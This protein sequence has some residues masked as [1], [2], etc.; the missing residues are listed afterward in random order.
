MM[1]V[2]PRGTSIVA[3]GRD[4]FQ[5]LDYTGSNDGIPFQLVH[6]A[7]VG[8]WSAASVVAATIITK[9]LVTDTL[10]WA[11]TDHTGAYAGVVMMD[12]YTARKISHHAV[13]RDMRQCS[14]PTTIVGMS[15]VEDGHGYM[16][17]TIPGVTT[18]VY[19]T[20]TSLWHERE[21]YEQ[22]HWNI[23]ATCT[24]G[25][26]IVGGHR[27][28]PKLYWVDPETYT[29]AGQPLVM[30]L[31]TPP[32]HGY[33]NQIEMNALYLDCQTGV[34][35]NTTTPADL[36]PTV[37]MRMSRDGETWGTELSRALGRQG[38]S[39]A[40]LAWHGLGTTD[41]RGAS[42]QFRASAAV[43]LSLIHISEPTRPCH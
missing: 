43:V 30:T 15:W 27:S 8:C 14:D 23:A 10:A 13:D 39:Q 29:E 25:N 32:L 2:M 3:F 35:L 5:V 28:L 34:G 36:D 24:L 40:R 19:D 17:W 21:S 22:G 18:W 12:G 31:Q 4:A 1:R 33:P 7:R 37:M 6:T 9:E 20:A 41:H 26:R 42:F 38:H 16:A 11:S